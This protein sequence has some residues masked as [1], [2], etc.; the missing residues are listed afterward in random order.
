MMVVNPPAQTQF[1][2]QSVAA[3]SY[4]PAFA[5]LN[6]TQTQL[7]PPTLAYDLDVA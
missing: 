7:P 4:I 3:Y 5:N 1:T 6:L 2:I